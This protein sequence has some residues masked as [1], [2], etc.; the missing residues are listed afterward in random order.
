MLYNIMSMHSRVKKKYLTWKEHNI[1]LFT[2]VSFQFCFIP[3]FCETTRCK[4]AVYYFCDKGMFLKFFIQCKHFKNDILEIGSTNHI[5]F[6]IH[7]LHFLSGMW[8][9]H[10]LTK[11]KCIGMLH[12]RVWNI[13]TQYFNISYFYIVHHPTTE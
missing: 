3:C 12:Y 9:I 2:V 1:V 5:P 6:T 13:S 11:N 10:V 4:K 8:Q 7:F